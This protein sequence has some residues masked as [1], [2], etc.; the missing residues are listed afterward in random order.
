MSPA[1]LNAGG[2]P[3]SLAGVFGDNMVLQRD[4]VMPVWG[5]AEPGEKVAVEFAGQKKS[6]TADANGQW[7]VKLDPMGVCAESR[8]LAVESSIKGRAVRIS[9]VLVGEVW[10]ASGQSNIGWELQRTPTTA[11]LIPNA[12][13]PLLRLARIP[14]LSAEEPQRDLQGCRWFACTPER[15]ASF[16]AVAYVF[17]RDLRQSLN[18]PVGIV[19]ASMPSSTAQAWTP[20]ATLQARPE[21]RRSVEQYLAKAALSPEPPPAPTRPALLYNA[22]IAPLTH[23]PIRG[24]IWYQAEGN[25]GDPE[26]YETLFPAMIRSWREAF[27]QPSLPFL[28]VQLPPYKGTPPMMR[29]VQARCAKTVP[30][31]AMVVTLDLGEPENIHPANKEPVGAR[32]ALKA[33]ALVYGQNLEH[34]GP[35]C[36]SVELRGDILRVQFSHASGGLQSRAGE[37]RGFEI[38]GA[39]GKYFAAHATIDG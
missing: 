9:N 30:H 37:P 4:A 14:H 25:S 35:E 36:E 34:S 26:L 29:E 39:D 32:L 13:D 10:L 21:L 2:N 28:F 19:L 22:R 17:G 16:S 38:A 24:V 7:R 3:L 27:S 1:M 15:G 8:P 5:W 33:R 12:N 11:A 6:A 20:M 31:T 18:V 23:L